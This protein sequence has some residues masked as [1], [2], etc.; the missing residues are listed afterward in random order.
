[1]RS[2]I[3]LNIPF[4][5]RTRVRRVADYIRYIIPEVLL[6]AGSVL[7]LLAIIRRCF[8]VR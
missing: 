2:F 5:L 3:Q 1:M 8:F 6:I 4:S 7:V